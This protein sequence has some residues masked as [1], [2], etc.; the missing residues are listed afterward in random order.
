MPTVQ[1]R[2]PTG[3]ASRYLTQLCR[4][5][6][7]IGGQESQGGHGGHAGSMRHGRTGGGV[8]ERGDIEIDARWTDTEGV[9]GFAPHGR[10]LVKAN[11][12]ELVVRIE[13]DEEDKLA[14]IQRIITDDLNRFG[15]RDGLDVHWQRIEAGDPDGAVGAA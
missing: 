11:D 4:H 14:R 2:I 3:R 8:P 10:C 9:I 5:A 1:T 12:T 6:S 13:A 7:R 15:H